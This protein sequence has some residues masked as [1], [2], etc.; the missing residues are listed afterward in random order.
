MKPKPRSNYYCTHYKI[1]GHSIGRCFKVHGFPACF[2]QKERKFAGFVTNVG[3]TSTN[4]GTKTS[5]T[6]SRYQ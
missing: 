2:K 3:E 6:L 5:T 1:P 4:I